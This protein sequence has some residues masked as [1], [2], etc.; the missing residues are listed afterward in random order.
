MRL[1]NEHSDFECFGRCGSINATPKVSSRH[2]CV[3]SVLMYSGPAS[4]FL[5]TSAPPT[6]D[7]SYALSKRTSA[8][9]GRKTRAEYDA[10]C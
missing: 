7:R 6:L 1:I 4:W 5:D 10:E 8:G 2:T 9:E 3:Q